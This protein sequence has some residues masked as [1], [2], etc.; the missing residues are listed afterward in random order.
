MQQNGTRLLLLI[1][2]NGNLPQRPLLD[3]MCTA[4]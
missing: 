4:L 1:Y 2:V 3:E